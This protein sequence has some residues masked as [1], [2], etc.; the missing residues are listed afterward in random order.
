MAYTNES[1][2]SNVAHE[3]TSIEDPESAIA[4]AK[5]RVLHDLIGS[6]VWSDII[7]VSV[8]VTSDE[9]PASVLRTVDFDYNED[10]RGIPTAYRDADDDDPLSW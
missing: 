1:A 3:L 5:R 7:G 4:D 8:R 6:R 2:V 9:R 10:A